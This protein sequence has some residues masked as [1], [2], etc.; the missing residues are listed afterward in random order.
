MEA[1]AATEMFQERF[2][3]NP[4]GRAVIEAMDPKRFIAIQTKLLKLFEAGAHLPVMG[5]TEEQ[6][7]SIKAPTIVIPGNDNTHSTES[8]RTAHRMIKGSEIHELP[9]EHQ[10]EPLIPFP[11]WTPHYPEITR[12]FTD[13]M[14][15]VAAN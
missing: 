6:L 2:A 8:G 1:V 7:A 11:E 3:E 13:F 4:T 10:D 12:V 9:I 14:R 5:V 15:R